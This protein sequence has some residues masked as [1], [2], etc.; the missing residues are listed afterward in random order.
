MFSN[1]VCIKCCAPYRFKGKH[2]IHCPN[3]PFKV[4]ANKKEE[5]PTKPLGITDLAKLFFSS[6]TDEKDDGKDV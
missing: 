1:I 4:Y 2:N 5:G 3:N 6:P